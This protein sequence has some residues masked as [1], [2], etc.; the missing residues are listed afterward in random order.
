MDEL[1]FISARNAAWVAFQQWQKHQYELR[2]AEL[3]KRSQEQAQ[4]VAEASVKWDLAYANA[5]AANKAFL[6]TNA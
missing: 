3:E 4:R 6:S 1:D 5:E 2:I